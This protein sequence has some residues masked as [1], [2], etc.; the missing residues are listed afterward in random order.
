M[1]AKRVSAAAGVILA[2]Q[3]QRKTALGIAAELEAACLLQSP[4]SAAEVEQLRARIAELEAAQTDPVIVSQFDTAIEPAPG[5]RC[6]SLVR[7]RH[8][9]EPCST[10]CCT[11]ARSRDFPGVTPSCTAPHSPSCCCGSGEYRFC[12]ASLGRDEYPF[13]CHRRVAHTGPCSGELD[14][15]VKP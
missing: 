14:D 15:E 7:C 8:Y 9:G 6:S 2:A 10:R 5:E 4:E 3:K 13:T 1:N 12:G 11:R